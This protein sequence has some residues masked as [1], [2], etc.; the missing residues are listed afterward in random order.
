MLKLRIPNDVR[1][2]Y[3]VGVARTGSL[4]VSTV[5]ETLGGKPVAVDR[6]VHPHAAVRNVCASDLSGPCPTAV[7]AAPVLPPPSGE[8]RGTLAAAD[9]PVIGKI[10]KPWVGTRS[11]PAR[12]NIAATTCDKASFARAGPHERPRAPS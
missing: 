3:V 2:T 1:R 6:A 12:P 8:T 4:T 7:A 9:L 11:V 5:S 10:N